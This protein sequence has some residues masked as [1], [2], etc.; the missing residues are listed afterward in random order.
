MKDRREAVFRYDFIQRPGHPIEGLEAL[1]S[2]VE[3]ETLDS[4]LGDETPR[5]ARA[6]PALVRVDARE[7]DHHV[8]VLARSV[9][10]LLIRYASTPDLALAVHRE[11]HEAQPALT[12][13]GD[14]LRNRRPLD[15]SEVLVQGLV[16]LGPV[17]VEG[18]PARGLGMGVDV[19]GHQICKVHHSAPGLDPGASARLERAA[20]A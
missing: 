18:L 9:G 3:L 20:S 4:M 2:R 1:H 19:D 13:V 7:G 11:H 15:S 17:G 14:R 16:E 10:H 12:V 8:G 6:H 5:F